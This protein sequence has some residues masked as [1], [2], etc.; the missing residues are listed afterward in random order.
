MKKGKMSVTRHRFIRNGDLFVFDENIEPPSRRHVD[1]RNMVVPDIKEHGVVS[2]DVAAFFWNDA[3]D[4]NDC[5][6]TICKYKASRKKRGQTVWAGWADGDWCALSLCFERHVEEVDVRQER[7]T[8][9][10][11]W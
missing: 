10:R 5:R 9:N 3:G 7:Q 8:L 6:Y 1:Q 2:G 4:E 11:S